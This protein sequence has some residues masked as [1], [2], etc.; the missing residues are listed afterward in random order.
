MSEIQKKLAAL[1]KLR[2]GF[3]AY[4]GAG[5]YVQI[6][7]GNNKEVLPR[8]EFMAEHLNLLAVDALLAQALEQDIRAARQNLEAD[9]REINNVLEKK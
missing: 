6:V 7:D 5:L 4:H 2:K 3:D 8:T 9:L 1:A